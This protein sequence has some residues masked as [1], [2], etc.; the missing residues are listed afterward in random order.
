MS[1][2]NSSNS[3]YLSARITQKGRNSIAKGEFIINYFQIGDSD[4]TTI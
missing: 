4:L 1:F 3:E 2:L